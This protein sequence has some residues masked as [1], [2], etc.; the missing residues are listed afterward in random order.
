ML[1]SIEVERWSEP[2]E[3]QQVKSL[4]MIKAQDAFNQLEKHLKEQGLLPDEYFLFSPEN[5]T[6]NDGEL[7]DFVEALC[8]TDFGG[9][10]GIYLDISLKYE[11]DGKYRFVH[12]AT[13]KTLGETTEAF[14][15]M[16]RIGAEC[17]MM[18]NGRGNNIMN[19]LDRANRQNEFLKVLEPHLM[20]LGVTYDKK[21]T[22]KKEDVQ[23]SLHGAQIGYI[24][25]SED[26]TLYL[27]HNEADE[28]VFDKIKQT[29][30]DT[31]EAF[32]AYTSAMPLEVE[33]ESAQTYRKLSE[34]NGIVLAAK[35]MKD[36]TLQFVTWRRSSTGVNNGNYTRNYQSAK[37]DFALRS[38]M[39][40]KQRLFSDEELKLIQSALDTA[41]RFGQISK[42]PMT[43]DEERKLID[44]SEKIGELLPKEVKAVGESPAVQSSPMGY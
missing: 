40:D 19:N 43:F 41:Q 8:D 31:M 18:L 4:G 17:S 38:E 30:R 24:D 12:F 23:L 3:K 21:V 22:G 27:K 29:F 10:E 37:E 15:C 14:Y 16:A 25:A 7:P 32:E 2:N 13:G 1:K 39:I 6:R 42:E 28:P 33:D 34:L 5:F 36:N 9:S 26:N 11:E 20:A 35:M 44:L